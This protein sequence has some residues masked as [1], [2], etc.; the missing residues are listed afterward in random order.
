MLPRRAALTTVRSVLAALVVV[1]M[2]G[3]LAA[4]FSYR[5][6]VD[7]ARRQVRERVTQQGRLYADSLG[8]HFEVIRAELQRQADR[9]YAALEA[10]TPEVLSGVSEDRAIFSGGVGLY[11]AAG[12][13]VWSEPAGQLPTQAGG[14]TWFRLALESDRSAIDE[15]SG[16][17]TSRLAVALPVKRDGVLAGV[18][19]GVVGAS[20]RLLYGV[21]GPGE[22]LLLLS[23]AEHVVVPLSEPSWSHAPGFDKRVEV[24]RSTGGDATW[25]LDGHEVMAE[26]FPVKNTSLQVLAL[27]SEATSVAPIRRRLNLQLAFLLV[28]QLV[29]L[30]A[31]VLFLRRTWRAF[32]EAEARVADAEKMAALGTAA[33]L[34][35]HE[36]KNSLN[37]LQAATG[38]L[39]SGGDAALATRT[40]KGQVDRL[41]HLARSLLSFARPSE[42]KPVK[43]ELDALVRDTVAGLS[44]LPEWPEAQVTLELAS[45]L[46]LETDPLLLTTALD[47]VVRNA[48]EAV[49]AAK[50]LGRLPGAPKVVVR[51]RREP[52]RAVIE[53]EDESGGAPPDFEAQLGRPFFTTR[54]RGI[55]LGLSMA[56]KVMEQLGGELHFHRTAHGSRFVF[57]VP[58]S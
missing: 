10:R 34:I 31:F 1:A 47:N 32:L 52:E 46:T 14:Q 56:L 35:A 45:S 37:G 57:H 11:D 33:S 43:V 7:E 8:L 36:V 16:D 39:E 13:L 9:G 25:D 21:E 44:T 29:A 4:V 40:M 58:L 50:D 27:E 3:S 24:L 6:D 54:P 2:L 41:G 53:V 26:A 23:S 22:Q 48:V 19:V 5:A 38:L 42:L 18:L 15:L 28:V 30:G 12:A 17:D 20:D 55:G 51:T 49:V